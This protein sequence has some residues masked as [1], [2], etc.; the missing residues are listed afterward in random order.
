[1]KFDS[2]LQYSLNDVNQNLIL[3]CDNANLPSIALLSGDVRRYGYGP[4]E[5]SPHSIQFTNL[6]L[7]W[8]IDK[9]GRVV[10]F[11]KNWFESIINHSSK[12]G[13]DMITKKRGTSPY[14]MGYKDDF[15]CPELNILVYDTDNNTVLKYKIYDV[16]PSVIEEI[17]LNWD[18]KNTMIRMTVQFFYT[19]LEIETIHDSQSYIN[20]FENIITGN[21]SQDFFNLP[22]NILQPLTFT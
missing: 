11:F 12:G 20:I 21:D 2:Y 8:I 3:R 9:N 16:Y 15:S 1:M 22:N 18:N 14:E 4:I 10:K 19:D 7:S 5:K 13:A 6:N 17:P